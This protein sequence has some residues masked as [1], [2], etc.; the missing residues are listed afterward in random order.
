MRASSVK[1]SLPT[2]QMDAGDDTHVAPVALEDGLEQQAQPVEHPGIDE[3][4]L[5]ALHL[6][7]AAATH[8]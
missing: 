7:A 1:L 6:D 2:H 4:S 3:E 8:D 5:S